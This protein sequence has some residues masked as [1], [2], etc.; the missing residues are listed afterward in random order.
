MPRLLSGNDISVHLSKQTAKGAIDSTPAFDELRRTEGKARVNT[1]YVQSNEVKTNRQARA[2]IEDSVSYAAELSFMINKQTFGYLIDAIQGTEVSSTDTSATIASDADGFVDSIGT[3]FAGMA[4]GDYIFISGFADTTLNRNYRIATYTSNQNIIT[5]PVP[6]AVEAE[7]ATVTVTSKRTTSGSTIAYYAVQT[8]TVD[9]SKAGS[10]DYKSFYDFQF[11]NASIEIGET[12]SMTGSF[13]MVGE[14]LTSGTAI[15]SGQ[16]NNTIDSSDD[17]SNVNNV[18]RIWIDGVDSGC[19]AKSIGFDF[20]NNL[21][22]D[23]AAGCDGEEFANGDI[24]LS[25][26]L[27]ARLPIDAP[28]VWRDRYNDKTNVALAIELDHG[29]GDYTIIEIPQT[30]I[31]DHEMP[32]GTNVVSNSEMTYTAE[33]DSRGFTAVIY[34]NWA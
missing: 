26:S 15:I 25:G 33:E 31:T 30:I 22:S 13:A 14:N 34:R 6:T 2:N 7:G 17:L 29:G 11:N 5:A 28:L 10:I 3:A 27:S 18:V 21:Q 12:G 19:T 4:V 1:S 23:R 8:R 20:S 9:T 16:T 24:T 32:D